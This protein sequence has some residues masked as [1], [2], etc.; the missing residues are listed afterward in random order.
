MAIPVILHNDAICDLFVSVTDLNVAGSPQTVTNL[1]V[2]E[3]QE[4]P[5]AVQEDGD[6]HGNI[7]WSAQ[8][9]DDPTMNKQETRRVDAGDRISVT[10]S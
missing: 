9:T 3:G 5:M 8:R 4:F 2:N 6:G 10:A 7:T 1:R